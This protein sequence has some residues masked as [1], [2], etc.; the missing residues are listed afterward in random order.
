MFLTRETITTAL[1][2]LHGTADHMLKIWFVLKQMGMSLDR[3]VHITTS[4]PDS[5][6]KRLFS[7]GN[8]VYGVTETFA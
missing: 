4:S 3:S 7:Y 1:E 2:K 8:K 6:L 5:A